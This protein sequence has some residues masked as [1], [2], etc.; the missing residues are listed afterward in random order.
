MA[1]EADLLQGEYAVDDDGWTVIGA[2]YVNIETG[3]I[4]PMGDDDERVAEDDA[5]PGAVH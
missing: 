1:S 4:V 2:Y 3:W 5:G